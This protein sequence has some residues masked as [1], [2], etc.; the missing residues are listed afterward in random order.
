MDAE[1]RVLLKWAVVGICG[2]SALQGG[3]AFWPEFRGTTAQ[4]HSDAK[5][6]PTE[7]SREKNIVWR[8]ELT[9]RA[10]SSPIVAKGMVFL[11]NAV[12]LEVGDERKGVSLRVLA[13][14]ADTGG[15]SWDTEV[16]RVTDEAAL[17]MNKKNSHASPTPVYEAGRIFAHFGHYGTACL[18]ENGKVLWSNRAHSHKAGHGIGG[19]P[20]V[21][22]EVL[23][24][25][26]DANVSPGVVALDKG[27]GRTRWR[28]ERPA[29]KARNTG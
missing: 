16:F 26:Q 11:T 23:I 1:L 19:S 5:G 15:V 14:D 18:D 28:V 25:N 13:F 8:A 4:G 7:W 17:R 21:V 29:T 3:E 12:P 9:G 6:L 22:R 24:F 27:T 2:G 10:W 20:V